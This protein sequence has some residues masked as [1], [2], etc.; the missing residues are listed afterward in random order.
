MIAFIWIS[1]ILMAIQH[2][3]KHNHDSYPNIA[4]YLNIKS[5]YLIVLLNS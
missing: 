5:G 1:I 4:E 2:I 3:S